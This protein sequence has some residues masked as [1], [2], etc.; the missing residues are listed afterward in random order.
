MT[1][2]VSPKWSTIV[3]SVLFAFAAQPA[4][5]LVWYTMWYS[6]ARPR[7][8]NRDRRGGAAGGRD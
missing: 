3:A 7:N 1:S 5:A 2:T 6:M 4:A 8:V